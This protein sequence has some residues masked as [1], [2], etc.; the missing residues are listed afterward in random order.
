M[1]AEYDVMD[2]DNKKQL[3]LINDRFNEELSRQV[4]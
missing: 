1:F 3:E 2:A 4:Q